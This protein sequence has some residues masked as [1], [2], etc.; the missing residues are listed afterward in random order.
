MNQK[1][2]DRWIERDETVHWLLRSPDIS[3]LDFFKRS[4][5]KDI[6]FRTK[7]RNINDPKQ[8]ITNA[9]DK[10]D[11]AMLQKTWQEIDHRLD[12]LRETKDAHIE[13]Y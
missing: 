11:G 6:V 13:N 4:Y 7:I 2:P 10:I 8:N 12:I 1:F 3:P 5:V 9:S